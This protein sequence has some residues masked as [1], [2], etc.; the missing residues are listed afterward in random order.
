VVSGIGPANARDALVDFSQWLVDFDQWLVDSSQW[1][2]EIAGWGRSVHR[3]ARPD[4][5]AHVGKTGPRVT[6]EP[7]KRF[8]CRRLIIRLSSKGDQQMAVDNSTLITFYDSWKKY[9]DRLTAA[10][11]PLTDAQLQ[12]A[13]APG[14][15][16]I[17][18]IATHMIGARVGWFIE[19][20]GEN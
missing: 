16:T 9:Q 4:R 11:A 17:G 3:W 19:V 1:S 10:L 12:L 8:T 5:P 18:Q 20:L 2:G 14:L 13:A 7:N 15:R 6:L